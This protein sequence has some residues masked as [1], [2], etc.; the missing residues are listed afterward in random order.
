MKVSHLS[1]VNQFATHPKIKE[2]SVAEHSYYVALTTL[3]ICRILETSGQE[4]G[5]DISRSAVSKALLH[6]IEECVISD[7][8]YPVK[9]HLKVHVNGN[10]NNEFRDY[11]IHVANMVLNDG[12]L[13]EKWI[14]SKSGVSGEI[15]VAA[16]RIALIIY[17][18]KEVILGNRFAEDEI[19]AILQV[20]KE[21]TKDTIVEDIVSDFVSRVAIWQDNV[22]AHIRSL[23]TQMHSV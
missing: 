2:I 10:N 16:D 18:M 12:V 23:H 21:E 11:Q 14:F 8:P 20:M 6:D 4:V 3:F 13:V 17:L 19:V 1:D 5:Q 15:V 22:T 7:I 9:K